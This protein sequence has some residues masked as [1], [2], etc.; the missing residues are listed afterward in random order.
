MTVS[1]DLVLRSWKAARLRQ[2]ARGVEQRAALFAV[3][4][5]HNLPP[6]VMPWMMMN[7]TSAT[8]A[9]TSMRMT[10]TCAIAQTPAAPALVSRWVYLDPRKQPARDAPVPARDRA[11]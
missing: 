9:R 8:P 3:I 2:D 11:G 4:H 1:I 5:D 10:S 7:P 6:G